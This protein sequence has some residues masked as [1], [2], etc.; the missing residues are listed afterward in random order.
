MSVWCQPNSRNLATSWLL[1]MGSPVAH[2]TLP[3]GGET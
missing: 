2:G 3:C 1:V